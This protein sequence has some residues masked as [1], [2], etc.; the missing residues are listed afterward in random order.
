M[1]VTIVS[2]IKRP[3]SRDGLRKQKF[4][5]R[6]RL[7]VRRKLRPKGQTEFNIELRVCP[8][9]DV[10]MMVKYNNPYIS[11]KERE[12]HREM[13]EMLVTLKTI[14]GGGYKLIQHR[15]RGARITTKI[16]LKK[17]ADMYMLTIAHPT[18]IC[19]AYEYVED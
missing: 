11:N 16:L 6:P 19:R 5:H 3:T 8:V 12:L 7:V 15:S 2:R 4:K 1:T 18:M 13:V 17:E 9:T 14:I 10:P